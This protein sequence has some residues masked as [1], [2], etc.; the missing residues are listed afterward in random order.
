MEVSMKHRM[1]RTEYTDPTQGLPLEAVLNKLDTEG[2]T[3]FSVLCP[4]K[5]Y[6][7][8]AWKEKETR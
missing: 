4:G 7:V 3:I 8:V 2:W 1:W 6:C 5:L